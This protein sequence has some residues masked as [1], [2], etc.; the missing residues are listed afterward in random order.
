MT[1]KDCLHKCYVTTEGDI[2]L[3]TCNFFVDKNKYIEV[4]RCKDCRKRHTTD[5]SLWYATLN[6]TEY[7]V[8]RGENFYCSYGERKEETK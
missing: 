2:D 7:L 1:C 8:E 4:V 5:C 6:G 3:E